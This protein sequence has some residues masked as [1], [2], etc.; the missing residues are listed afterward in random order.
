MQSPTTET[1]AHGLKVKAHAPVQDG[2]SPFAFTWHHGRI[3]L[4]GSIRTR[5]EADDM[6][7]VVQA[8]R[9]F[10]PEEPPG[11]VG[12]KGNDSDRSEAKEDSNTSH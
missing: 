12:A 1:H 3:T 9:D 8:L 4:G 11:T 6:L 7:K 10:L 5:K 2:E